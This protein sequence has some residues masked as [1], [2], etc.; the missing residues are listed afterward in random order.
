MTRVAEQARD[1][2][3]RLA[4]IDEL[5]LFDGEKIRDF[6]TR[7]A[8]VNTDLALGPSRE[9]AETRLLTELEP[10]LRRWTAER[11]TLHPR[12]IF[13]QPVALDSFWDQD[14]QASV[15]YCRRAV[16]PGEAHLR[17]AAAKLGAAWHEL[18]T[19]HYP[20]LTMPAEVAQIIVE[21]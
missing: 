13:E 3:G 6:V 5:A 20:M 8:A 21:G 11:F 7:P 9:D 18:D 12:A 1:R 19:G 10:D 16:D 17:R 14:W 4:F 15:V 2:V